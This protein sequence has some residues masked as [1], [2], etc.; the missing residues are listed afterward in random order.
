MA[1]SLM[2]GVLSTV[3]TI[4]ID[5]MV[6]QIQQ[7][8][9]AGSKVSVR[10]TFMAQFHQGGLLQMI[11]FSTKGFVARVTHVAFTTMLMK[12]ATSV[13]YEKYQAKYL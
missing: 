10:E 12:T 2:G 6:A 4:P 9:N 8:S 5:V 3:A 11:R 7:A 1:A 13:I